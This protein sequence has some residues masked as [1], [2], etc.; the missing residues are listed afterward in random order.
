MNVYDDFADDYV[1]MVDE[2][3]ADPRSVQSQATNALLTVAG[4]VN[5]L[6]VVDLG[7][8]EGHLARRLA[9]YARQ[10]TG[11]DASTRLLEIAR[12]R[13]DA[14][15]VTYV[16]DD[17]QKLSRL[18]RNSADLV[19]CNLALIDMA[20]A[21]AVYASVYRVLRSGGRFVF[22]LTHPCFQSPDSNNEV[23]ADGHFV[24]RRIVRYAQPEQWWSSNADGVRGQVGAYHRSLSDIINPLVAVGFVL[25]QLVEP[26]EESRANEID[27]G[28]TLVPKIMVIAATR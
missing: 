1:R 21:G 17:A 8:G 20:D 7:C 27:T 12:S 16:H 18:P 26:V 5:G 2:G 4:S 25:N 11:V 9:S 19:L 6:D 24:A 13:T 22:S 28:L 3:L 23:D 15:N 14:S 10:V